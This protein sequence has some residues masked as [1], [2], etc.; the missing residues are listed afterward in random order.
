MGQSNNQIRSEIAALTNASMLQFGGS[1]RVNKPLAYTAHPWE[2][3]LE[4]AVSLKHTFWL[5]TTKAGLSDITT[6]VGEHRG[7]E[8]GEALDKE[9]HYSPPAFLYLSHKHFEDSQER[10]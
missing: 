6:R 3:H 1:A 5:L 8:P 9:S 2:T 4:S 7:M 10:P